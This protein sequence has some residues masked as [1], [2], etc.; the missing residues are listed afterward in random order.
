MTGIIR[1]LP[2]IMASALWA[3]IALLWPGNTASEDSFI[4]WANITLLTILSLVLLNYGLRILRERAERRAGSMLRAKLVIA[5]VSMLLIPTA[6]LQVAANQMVERGMDVWFDVRVDTLLDQALNLAQG[7]YARVDTDLK[8]GLNSAMNDRELLNYVSALPLSYGLLNNH[9]QEILLHEGWQSI[10][11]FDLNERLVANVK[12]EGL[13]GFEVEA[14]EEEA[15][16]ALT[17]G[18]ISTRFVSREGEEMGVGYAPLRA[19]QNIIG[20]LRAQVK[21]PESVVQNAR[22]VE[23]DYRTYRQLE[24][25]RQSIR[26]TFT[27]AMLV[28]TLLIIIAAGIV[29][30][31][32]ARRLTSPIGE[33]AN[34]LERVTEGDL[35]VSIPTAPEDEL[36]S[37]VH[38]FNRMTLRLKQNVQALERTQ[39]ELTGAL[40]SSRQRQYVLETLL[41][42]LQAGV[43]L[44]DAKGNIRLLNQAVRE[45][46][47]L[48]N[49]W[50]PGR[51]IAPLCSGRLHLVCQFYD[52]LQHQ[53]EGQLQRELEISVDHRNLHVLGRGVRLSGSGSAGFSGY[54]MVLDDVS[55]LAEAQRHRAWAEVAQRL[56]HEIKNPLT[57][58]KLAAERLQR[59]FRKTAD[60]T[61][62]FDSCTH[63]II[64]QVERLQRLIVDFSDLAR[65]PKPKP[66][67]VLAKELTTDM[68]ELYSAYPRLHVEGF[69]DDVE[70][71][72]DADQIRQVLINLMDNALAA[73][74]AAKAPV[75]LYGSHDDHMVEFH[76][77]DGGS[78]IS[79]DTAAHIFDAYFSTKED[80]S[81][82][83][84]AIAKR[85]ADEH[86]G[87]LL[88]ISN[89]QPTH[90]CLRLPIEEPSMEPS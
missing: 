84:L 86:Q 90:F 75:H 37:L 5:L 26:G 44:I 39:N 21:L 71:F 54:L 28:A 65:M 34:A 46:L 30:V 51:P 87:E 35:N 43:L 70:C 59:R 42:N 14:L 79:D 27:H 64:T 66:T 50:M 29:A 45:L 73:T 12:L 58:I 80:G 3:T 69:T 23:A 38:S 72:C 10:Q 81:G 22:A 89:S 76:V 8:Q 16:S 47:Q 25:N 67:A 36:G 57:P 74:E 61:E 4:A 1:Y 20:I 55:S 62:V 13:S 63:A 48:S 53:H 56:A 68:R 32:F 60:N 77:Q 41:A 49:D 15:R 85:I 18:L 33:L 82:L 6:I 40:D 7:F 88:L 31:A 19:H 9:L 2:L 52:E 24:R 17:L 78:G 83:G 11:I